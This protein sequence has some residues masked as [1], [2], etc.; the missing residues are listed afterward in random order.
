MDNFDSILNVSAVNTNDKTSVFAAESKENRNHCYD[1]SEK[2][3]EKIASDSNAFQ[4]FL[5]VQSRFDRYTANNALLITA[6]NPE[7]QKL[8][9][10]G[11]WREQGAYVKRQEKNNPIFILEPGKEY[12]R[13][14]G[15]IG[16]YYNAKKLYD[17]SQTT[18]QEKPQ[19]NA[20][21]E[22]KLL[23]KAIMILFPMR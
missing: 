14:D 23:K 7:A 2:M 20:I 11:Y 4:I 8:G 13:D 21:T 3:T 6:Q 16:T 1:M 18:L 17:I 5:D 22:K 9:N 12:T 15:S 10:Y 19:Q